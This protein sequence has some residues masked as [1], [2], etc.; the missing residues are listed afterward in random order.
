MHDSQPVEEMMSFLNL[1][2]IER[3]V[4]DKAYDMDKIR[5]FLK[6]N[7][8][9]AEIPNKK[10]RKSPFRFDKTVYKWQHRVENLFQKLK[11]NRRLCMRFD[12]LDCTFMAFVAIALIKLDVC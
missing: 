12:K 9:H 6:E 5:D 1:K 4:A 3:F 11:E 7:D 8:I 2:E 10:N